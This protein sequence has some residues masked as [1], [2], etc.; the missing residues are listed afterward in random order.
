MAEEKKWTYRIKVEVIG[1]EEN[2][3]N[4]KFMEEGVECDGF[5]ILGA[6]GDRASSSIHH[7]R[8]IDIAGM[9]EGNDTLSEAA[10]LKDILKRTRVSLEDLYDEFCKDG[11][12]A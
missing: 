11:D 6:M 1:E 7:V 9:I 12:G 8:L 3:L 4:E 5:V 10:K 2:K